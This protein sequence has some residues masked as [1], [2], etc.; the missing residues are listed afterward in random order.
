MT[1]HAAGRPSEHAHNQNDKLH[2]HSHLDPGRV[3]VSYAFA[4]R[5]GSGDSQTYSS[6]YNRLAPDLT[7]MNIHGYSIK[8]AIGRGG[9]A[10]AYLA[11]QESLGREVV[12]KVLDTRNSHNEGLI[13]RFLAEG[14]II[15]S[16]NH[17]NIITIYDIGIADNELY[18]S[19]EYVTGGDLKRRIRAGLTPEETLD[20]LT[21]L[22]SGLRAAHSRGIV[23]RDIKPAN[24]LFRAD[25]TPLITDFGI[26]K[27][28]E[29][30]RDLTTTGIFMGSPNYVS[31]EQ[32]DGLTVD[33][34]SDI[35]SLGCVF[36]EMLTGRKPFDLNS[37]IDIVIQHKQAPIPTL[38]QDLAEF[39]DLLNTMMAKRPKDRPQ[40]C[41]ALI[42][43]LEHVRSDR[44]QRLQSVIEAQYAKP[45]RRRLISKILMILLVVAAG[46]YATM[47]YVSST[48]EQ[49]I[50][51]TVSATT[52]SV[53]TND[54]QSL[55]TAETTDER[56]P[57]EAGSNKEEVI[58]ALSWLGRQSLEEYKLTYPPKDNAYY[59]FR[60]LQ[61]LDPNNISAQSGMK[62]IADRYAILA[63][64][65]LANNEYEKT[66]TYVSL[67]LRIDPDNQTLLSLQ[68][69]LNTSQRRSLLETIK[70]ML[71]LS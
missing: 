16:L 70:A 38:P 47:L 2:S 14:R 68:S 23:H 9:M 37:V 36:Y 18:I 53:L 27:Q 31:P 49:D 28:T 62:E 7:P 67:G 35:Y 61:E 20:C 44:Q 5:Q 65:A 15:A 12:L 19:M 39:Q 13:E 33:G 52:E 8:E 6:I 1:R 51:K 21:Q 11:I 63:E 60:K 50:D 59:Y 69:L 57:A 64:Q 10:T 40:N 34:R 45:Q 29:L 46:F 3:R 25:G 17:P 41:D 4:K 42:I 48:M 30:D 32:A 26:A 24:I 22:S 43:A 56:S 55:S 54:L 71:G 58:K 66:K